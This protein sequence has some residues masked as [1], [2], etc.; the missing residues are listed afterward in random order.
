MTASTTD[1]LYALLPYVHRL[2]DGERGNPLK[3]FLGVIAEQVAVL[4]ADLD[5]L[6][7]N[8]FIETCDESIVPYIGELVGWTQTA[9][10]GSPGEVQ[11]A[12]GMLLR[13]TLAP[14][15]D[16]ARTLAHRRRKGA[17]AL[18]EELARTVAGW[19]AHAVE[20]YRLL[21]YTQPI[22]HPRLERGRT[23]DLR[24]DDA[25]AWLGGPFETSAHTVDVRRATS[26]HGRGK[27]NIPSVGVFVWRVR[28]WP[29]TTCQAYLQEGIVDRDPRRRR[30]SERGCFHVNILGVDTPL[31][32]R[33]TAE[34]D[35]C[36]IAEPHH[37]PTRLTRH[38][39]ARDLERYYGEGRSVCIWLGS[40]RDG[41]EAHPVPVEQVAVAD[42]TEWAYAVPDD[43]TVLLDPEL[44]RFKV[45]VPRA[46]GKRY[47]EDTI[48][49]ARVSYHYGFSAAIG[50]GE[51]DRELLAPTEEHE[52][53]VVGEG[54]GRLPSL[55]HALARWRADAPARAIIEVADRDVQRGPI[56]IA[57]DEDQELVL[58]A[59]DR[60]R[61]V[62]RL[63]D[64]RAD[65][66]DAFTVHGER[67][68]RFV[69]DGFLVTGRSVSV[70]GPLDEVVFR[71]CTLVPPEGGERRPR[72]SGPPASLVL[73]GIAGDVRIER[74]IVGP[75]AVTHEGEPTPV[76]I[77]GSIVDAGHDGDDAFSDGPSG[78][79][80][81]AVLTIRTSTVF[82]RVT[83]HALALA[84][85][86]LFSGRVRVARRH[87]GCVRFCHVPVGS[88]TPPR[89]HCQPDLAMA[90]LPPDDAAGREREADRVWPV[91]TSRRYGDPG[92]A[93]LWHDVAREIARGA[94]DESEMGVMHDLYWP[95]R[96][97]A[98][99]QRLAEYVP[100]GADA[101]LF[102]VT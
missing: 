52:V 83:T 7:D 73:D 81:R 62:V 77:V 78:G 24:D 56:R 37:V 45:R 74:S 102:F 69:C 23:L 9:R 10:A 15:A 95:Q 79:H 71:H 85:S 35:A 86:S 19:P 84:E 100:A 1:R 41:H 18:L 59:A 101:G 60:H 12:E 70:T 27:Y 40:H 46:E 57:L 17:L 32:V 26:M 58:R 31:F 75:I 53:Y 93:Q 96:E 39:L 28:P 14:R 21:S 51:Y 8:W 68:S 44:G 36:S 33:P 94:D 20:L 30:S 43:K 42:L 92:Y 34:P 47:A 25:L 54:P 88:R 49:G 90:A 67:G 63:V 5:R 13:R 87:P 11:G 82:G 64:D 98:L 99:A 89:Y 16:V 38:L 48:G 29:V 65:A 80:A 2:R 76:T 4:E 97:D 55:V 6:Y 72:A 66:R 91:W 3:M 50:G 22:N 61:A